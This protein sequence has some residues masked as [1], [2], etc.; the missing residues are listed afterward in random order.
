MDAIS[1]FLLVGTSSESKVVDST[2]LKIMPRPQLQLMKILNRSS[3]ILCKST[4]LYTR[5]HSGLSKLSI[6]PEYNF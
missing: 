3:K 4:R 6:L 5:I 2:D 1:L